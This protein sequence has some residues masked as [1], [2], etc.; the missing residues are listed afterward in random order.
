MVLSPSE[1]F[2]EGWT[3]AIPDV[4]AWWDEAPPPLAAVIAQRPVSRVPKK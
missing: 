3:E 4:P 2:P 1:D